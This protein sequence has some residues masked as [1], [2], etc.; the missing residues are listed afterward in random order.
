MIVVPSVGS[1]LK[2]NNVLS[3]GGSSDGSC[4]PVEDEPLL[5]VPWGVVLNSQSELL[6]T[7]VL[8]PEDS[9]SATHSGSDLKLSSTLEWIL[10][11]VN[12][13]TV[14]QPCLVV[15][16]MASPPVNMSIVM[17]MA[18]VNIEAVTTDVSDVSLVSWE[19]GN[20]LEG[21]LW[22][23]LSNDS[24]NIDSHLLALLN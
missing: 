23:E 11:E 22:S 24:C 3:V 16:V 19:V 12:T 4:S 17:V 1:V 18:T 21:F 8:I 13:F 6:S 7:H 10:R 15:F 2:R 9:L 5:D 14:D 20:S